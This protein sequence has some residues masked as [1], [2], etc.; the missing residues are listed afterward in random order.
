[1]LTSL[2]LFYIAVFDVKHHRIPNIS[3]LLLV[4]SADI[5]RELVLDGF[6]LLLSSLGVAIFTIL[7]RCGYGDTKL[8]IILLNLVIPR[9]RI[10]DFL[11]LLLMT[12]SALLALHIV[13]NRSWRGE[14][15]FAPA[16]C[17]AVL[18]LT[19]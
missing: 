16:L 13:R 7:S 17:G 11:G 12:T 15:A 19:S 18:A 14:I 2:T 5:E 9:S 6:H 1:V 10:V 3:L 4:M 8:A